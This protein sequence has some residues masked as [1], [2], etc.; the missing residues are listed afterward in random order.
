LLNQYLDRDGNSLN[1][2]SWT[3][4]K[5]SVALNLS[6]QRAG[7][8]HTRCLDVVTNQQCEIPY[9]THLVNDVIVQPSKEIRMPGKVTLSCKQR[10]G[11]SIYICK[12]LPEQTKILRISSAEQV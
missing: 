8:T 10:N 3:M 1:C 9:T 2:D 7:I 12:F 6:H 11:S 5:N 4:H